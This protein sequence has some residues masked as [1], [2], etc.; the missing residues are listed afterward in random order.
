LRLRALRPVAALLGGATVLVA[1]AGPA[2]AAT[3]T[4]LYRS[5]RSAGVSLIGRT[6]SAFPGGPPLSAELSTSLRVGGQNSNA[7]SRIVVCTSASSNIAVFISLGEAIGWNSSRF[8]SAQHSATVSEVNLSNLQQRICPPT[9]AD[10]QN[11]IR[12]SSLQQGTVT[13]EFSKRERYLAAT[14]SV[15][16]PTLGQRTL[17]VSFFEGWSA[18]A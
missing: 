8:A 16:C 12:I 2:D 13:E 15:S 6:C 1:L 14:R 11:R 7:N 4:V 5:T 3:A 18:G 9:I 17:T 10:S